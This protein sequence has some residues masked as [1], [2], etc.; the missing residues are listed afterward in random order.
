MTYLDD[1]EIVEDFENWEC[2]G[3]YEDWL[4]SNGGHEYHPAVTVEFGELVE[5]GFI[6]LSNKQDWKWPQFSDEQDDNLREKIKNHFW[7]REIGIVPLGVW[8]R[9]FL[10]KMN[11]IMPKYIKMYAAL[12]E[13][14]NL[15][16]H[17][18]EWY[19]SRNIFSDYPATQLG[20]NSDYASTGNDTEY[21]RIKRA[22][23]L[24]TMERLSRYRDVDEQILEDLEELFSCLFSVSMNTR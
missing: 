20:G 23:I 12:A 10:A 17:E 11:E 6:D 3:K 13:D 22:D 5:G 14:G 24:E 16:G 1:F 7:N 19:K 9:Q 4:Y 21:E 2:K 15:A 8:K 18:G